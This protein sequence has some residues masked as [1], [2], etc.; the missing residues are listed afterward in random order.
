MATKRNSAPS[1]R[2]RLCI[3]KWKGPF[4]L[5][6]FFFSPSACVSL[7]LLWWSCPWVCLSVSLSG[8]IY[9][10]ETSP[11]FRGSVLFWRR[12]KSLCIAGFADDVIFPIVVIWHAPA[13]WR[14]AVVRRRGRRGRRQRS[15]VGV[16]PDVAGRPAATRRLVARGARRP[17][18][19]RRRLRGRRRRRRPDGR[20]R[21]RRRR[22][23]QHCV[24]DRDG[25]AHPPSG[26]AQHAAR[27]QRLRRRRRRRRLRPAAR[28]R[29]PLL[30]GRPNT[31]VAKS[32]RVISWWNK[33]DED[34]VS[35][36]SVNS[37][38]RK[39][40]YWKDNSDE[41]FTRTL[42]VQ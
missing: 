18:R 10:V 12:C 40:Q 21:R 42:I 31:S 17:G 24:G 3:K 16:E 11:C 41:F 6:L 23:L 1:I 30:A 36:P 20:G 2:S 35:A 28:L 22:P 8:S 27:A 5:F 19:H 29:K 32:E 38:K 15:Q 39:L 25:A 34:T 37:F 9:Q 7:D 26:T 13:V 4:V 33:L 14:A